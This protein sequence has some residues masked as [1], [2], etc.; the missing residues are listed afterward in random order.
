MTDAELEQARNE[1]QFWTGGPTAELLFSKLLATYEELR[2]DADELLQAALT[3]EKI[4]QECRRQAV[5]RYAKDGAELAEHKAALR[6]LVEA[7]P[8]CV[9][10]D[11]EEPST[12]V[13]YGCDTDCE[14]YYCEKHQWASS[15]AEWAEP[16]RKARKLLGGR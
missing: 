16:L 2:K 15:P 13:H 5:E 6:E 8:K 11:C 10:D 3:E 9:S 7:L 4:H 14:S 1:L 12:M